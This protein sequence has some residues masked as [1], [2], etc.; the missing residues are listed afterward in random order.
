MLAVFEPVITMWCG[1][2]ADLACKSSNSSFQCISP[3][4]AQKAIILHFDGSAPTL[5][6]WHN[7]IIELAK[8]PKSPPLPA[9]SGSYH[10]GGDQLG[11]ARALAD[12]SLDAA[13]SKGWHPDSRRVLPSCGLGKIA[14]KNV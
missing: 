8:S 14:V 1:C 11:P 13:P 10:A 3:Q 7:V 2:A 6:E 4:L 12:V 5:N 9:G